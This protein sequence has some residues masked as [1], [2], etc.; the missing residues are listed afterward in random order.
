M[1]LFRKI[2]G[3]LALVSFAS[4]VPAFQVSAAY[5]YENLQYQE[6]ISE[7]QIVGCDEDVTDLVIPETI[8]DKPVTTIMY[9]VFRGNENLESVTIPETMQVIAE[10]A[11]QDCKNLKKINMPETYVDIAGGAFS[12]TRWELLT[13]NQP[14]TYLGNMVYKTNLGENQEEITI[15]EGTLSIAGS[16]FWNDKNLKKVNLPNSLLYIGDKAF[17]YSGLTSIEIPESVLAIGEDAFRGT[18][19]ETLTVD[20]NNTHYASSENI[21]YDKDFTKFVFVPSSVTDVTVPDTIT[22]IPEDAFYYCKNLTNITLPETLISIGKDAFC[23]CENLTNITLPENLISIGEQAF[24]NSGITEITI[25]AS[26]QIIRNGAFGFCPNLKSVRFAE[27]T[28]I[29][30][31]DLVEIETIF[32]DYDTENNWMIGWTET[33]YEYW[34]A[35]LHSYALEKIYLPSTLQSI[36]ENAF[37]SCKNYQ[38]QFDIFYYGTRADWQNV[39]VSEQDN[40]KMESG[41]NESILKANM[42][43]MPASDKIIAGDV[44]LD[45][46][47]TILDLII[48]QKYM[49]NQYR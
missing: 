13:Y 38:N 11:F 37:G 27:G 14:V 25:P 28:K 20:E 7:I 22:E 33:S 24:E 42:H 49:L 44:D 16:A 4:A 21:L 18:E 5:T 43:Y 19:L 30:P 29:I 10:C 1:K 48:L 3:L 36:E 41:G 6:T 32:D 45:E 15:R 17:S 2:A 39:V 40:S 9:G 47:T 34:G 8:N 23:R 12:G 31:S 46:K 35:F 26:V